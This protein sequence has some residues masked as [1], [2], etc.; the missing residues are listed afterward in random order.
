[1][2]DILSQAEIDA[3]MAGLDSEPT[4]P[5][6]KKTMSRRQEITHEEVEKAVEQFRRELARRLD[7]KGMGTFTSSHEIIGCVGEEYDEAKV[8]VHDNDN[9]Q[10]RKELL[11]LA[12]GAVFGVACINAG[13]IDW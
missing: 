7:Q 10:L 2:D 6:E 8:A 12:V 1:M 4:P 3:L 11:D 9:G 13:K 5:K